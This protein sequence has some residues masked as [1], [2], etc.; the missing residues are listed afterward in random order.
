MTLAVSAAGWSPSQR[1]LSQSAEED[2]GSADMDANGG[3]VV[4][5]WAEGSS[6]RGL[7][8]GVIMMGWN[9][10]GNSTWLTRVVP[11]EGN[12]GYVHYHPTVALDGMTAHVAW[13][14][15][16]TAGTGKGATQIRYARCNLEFGLCESHVG[17]SP[18]DLAYARLA[19]D[20]AVDP[21][22]VPHVVWVRQQSAQI[23][24]VWYNNRVGGAWSARPE[25][26]SGGGLA[27]E[28]TQD[29]PA[30][31]VDNKH[32]YVTWDENVRRCTGDRGTAGIYFRLRGNSTGAAGSGI[33]WWP[34]GEPW[35]KQIS[36]AAATSLAAPY[37]VDGFPAIGVGEGWA[38]VVWERLAYS[39]SLPL[40]GA[41][42]TYSLAYRVYTGTQ[43]HRDWWPGGASTDRW[44]VLPFTA[45]SAT[46]TAEYYAGLRPAIDM[47]GRTPHVAWH[48]WEAPVP[49][50]A[51]AEWVPLGELPS[52]HLI[53]SQYPYRVSY[54]TYR[55]GIDPDDL[56]A[57]R[58][59]WVSKTL[60]VLNS[61]RILAWPALALASSDGGRTHVLHVAL[62]RRREFV[63]ADQSYAWDVVYTNENR[64]YS[65][66]L[67]VVFSRARMDSTAL[68]RSVGGP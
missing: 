60:E 2:S 59:S 61:D 18:D 50:A 13:V 44:A 10:V 20:I 5:V 33:N 57:A 30:V 54:A 68:S 53:D 9:R 23:G 58:S 46:D 37:Q 34:Q 64:Y 41:V 1:N 25:Q 31:A 45:T 22:G 12:A 47:A 28:Y 21:L 19:P 49:S 4:V 39:Q 63:P 38:Y 56:A 24:T 15:E 67:P 52:E 17:I 29:N 32:V 36:E 16:D 42:Y 14:R 7:N 51:S 55:P 40:Y 62:H 66:Y 26:V 8:D 3:N 43:P 65:A 27:C 6:A 11:P 35:G 48:Q